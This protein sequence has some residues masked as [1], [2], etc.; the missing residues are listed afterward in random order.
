M[1]QLLAKKPQRTAEDDVRLSA[2]GIKM[3]GPAAFEGMRRAGRLAA[4]ALDMIVPH[5]VPG[6]VTRELDD[7]IYEFVRAAGAVPATSLS[8]PG[9]PSGGSAST[10]RS[11]RRGW[12]RQ[13]AFVM[14]AGS[15]A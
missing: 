9:S 11:F 7:R 6:A 15:G 14:F 2:G 13:K 4:E 8:S 12:T 10:K 5:V 3:H 1:E